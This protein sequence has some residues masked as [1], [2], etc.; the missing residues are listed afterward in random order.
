MAA[1]PHIPAC[2]ER[3]KT[4][5]SV[6]FALLLPLLLVKL[7][8]CSSLLFGVVLLTLISTNYLLP[9]PSL[10]LSSPRILASFVEGAI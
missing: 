5:S 8:I 10:S 7:L 3:H 2:E 6:L 1:C 4:V 9:P